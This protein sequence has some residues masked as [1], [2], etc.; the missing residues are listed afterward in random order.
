[1][2]GEGAAAAPDDD[3]P[4]V[5]G[6]T[7]VGDT[8]VDDT[9]EVDPADTEASA[10]SAPRATVPEPVVTLGPA[11]VEAS[12]TTSTTLPPATRVLVV[13]SDEGPVAALRVAALAGHGYDVIDA[14]QR[15]CPIATAVEL[16]LW[17][18][19]LLSTEHCE[20]SATQWARAVTDAAPDVV[21]VSA[22]M[23]DRAKSRGPDDD[24]FAAEKDLVAAARRLDAEEADLR[25]AMAVVTA[26]GADVWVVDHRRDAA[27]GLFDERLA[28]IGL[29]DASVRDVIASDDELVASIDK[30]LNAVMEV[31]TL[32]V[33]VI[34]DSVSLNFARALADGIPGALDVMWAGQNG[35]PFVRARAIRVAPND[36]WE[37]N[38]CE[39][40]D[41]KLPPLLDEYQPDIVVL[42]V[43]LRE[44]VEQR[45]GDDEAAHLVGEPG[46]TAFHDAEMAA[47]V[48]L[49]EPRS[50]PLLVTDTAPIVAGAMATRAMADPKRIAAWNAQIQRWDESWPSVALLEYAGPLVAY[51]AEHGKIR[52]DGVHPEIDP[53]T[54]L[55]RSV[56]VPAVIA[57]T[58]ELQATG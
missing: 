12:T 11:S 45:Y 7:V 41:V 44:L 10:T 51:E 13:G 39:P 8:V 14:V 56:Y 36:P 5:V 28:R 49:L 9:V 16:R 54:E 21:V 2:S 26:S 43:S 50:I 34:G 48:G 55:A 30:A 24:G 42:M 57:Q 25:A 35:C 40:F 53:L 31:R 18:G 1:M 29:T 46:Y 58:R 27:K 33:L 38:H 20:P 15:G 19:S 22:G 17:D 37:E 32:R 4:N 3:A 52:N 47:L 23:L 6:D